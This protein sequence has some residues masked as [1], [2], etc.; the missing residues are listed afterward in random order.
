MARYLPEP[1]RIKMVEPLRVT[2]KEER[3]AAIRKAHYNLFGLKAMM[4]T[5]TCLPTAERER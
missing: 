1:Y 3:S 4:S 5:S 2:T